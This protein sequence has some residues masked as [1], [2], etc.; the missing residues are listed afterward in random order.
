[1]NSIYTVHI[2][3]ACT[4][5]VFKNIK[6]GSTQL[7][8]HLKIIL[9]QCFQF[10]IS[11]K[12]SCIQTDPSVGLDPCFQTHVCVFRLFFF[13]HMNSNIIW[14][15]CAGD[16]KYYSC[17][18]HGSHDTIHTFKNYFDTIFSVFS[19]GKN[20]LYPNRPKCGFGS[21][22]PNPRLHFQ[23]LFFSST[24]TVTSHEFIV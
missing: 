1:M 13:Q 23:T 20:K 11:A 2:L 18:V 16:K 12:I 6:N 3:C 7:F 17:T 8:T 22:F 10:S 5:Y 4:V 14:I 21:A 15:Y 24:W 19:F 9:L